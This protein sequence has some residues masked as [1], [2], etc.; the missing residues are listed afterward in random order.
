[1][2]VFLIAFI[3]GII[4]SVVLITSIVIGVSFIGTDDSQITVCGDETNGVLRGPW[5]SGGSKFCAPE[6]TKYVMD[7][8]EIQIE[9]KQICYSKDYVQI[10]MDMNTRFSVNQDLD[11]YIVDV[12][13][14]FGSGSDLIED[15]VMDIIYSVI[16]QV[17][18]QFEAE[19]FANNRVS[20]IG[21]VKDLVI[22]KSAKM[23][24]KIGDAQ[25][26]NFDY[27]SG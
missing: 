4:G 7:T 17:C 8:T 9:F 18:P 22:K 10:D 19:E 26:N 21:N 5:N 6:N 1:M 12:F 14:V 3:A 27:N 11:T 2:R 15:M 13:N 25:L 23:P 16:N 24:I 20:V